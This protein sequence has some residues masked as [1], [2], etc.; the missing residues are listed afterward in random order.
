MAIAFGG[1][2]DLGNT[3]ATSLTAAYNC[4]AGSDRFLVVAVIGDTGA[5]FEDVTGVTYP[6]ATSGG[7][8]VAMTLAEKISDVNIA[9]FGY[10]FTLMNPA[11][12]TNNVVVSCTNGHF[13]AAGAAHWNGVSQ[14]GQPEGTPTKVFS[15]EDVDFSLTTSHTPNTA[16]SW[17]IMG[18]FGFDGSGA[19]PPL[20]GT[21]STR[22][23]YEATFG[24]WGIFDSDSAQPASSYSMEWHYASGSSADLGSIMI[25]VAPASGSSASSSPSSSTSASSSVSSSISSS[26]SSSTS[27]GSPLTI[28]GRTVLDYDF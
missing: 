9:R 5:G 10:L 17:V 26:V 7:A 1:A 25:A 28:A 3:S 14:T 20:A 4:G 23:T 16:N 21:G 18:A 27:P 13:L 8:G 24:L 19:T 2:T 11:S 6:T 22:R 15:N 12:G